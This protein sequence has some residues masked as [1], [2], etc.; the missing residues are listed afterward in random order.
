LGQHKQRLP[1]CAYLRSLCIGSARAV[2]DRSLAKRAVY[3]K[4][5]NKDRRAPT[6]SWYP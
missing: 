5:P 1:T 3:H 2:V 4:V 6:Q